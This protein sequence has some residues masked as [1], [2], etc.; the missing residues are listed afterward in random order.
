MKK[1]IIFLVLMVGALI[2]F[3]VIF[4][5]PFI[6]K[7]AE[8]E[9]AL[10]EAL[11][12]VKR[13]YSSPEGPPSTALIKAMEAGDKILEEEYARMRK[14]L[15]R[16][17]NFEVPEGQNPVLYFMET[18]YQKKKE[19]NEYAELKGAKLPSTI[20]GL[21]EKLPS[22]EEVPEL[23]KNL[24]MVDWLIKTFLDNQVKDISS[25]SVYKS[26]DGDIYQKL[27]LTIS[28]SC[29][30]LSFTKLLYFLENNEEKFVLI[31]DLVIASK[32]ISRE[33][34]VEKP[35]SDRIQ[36]SNYR[37]GRKGALSDIMGVEEVKKKTVVKKVLNVTMSISIL[38]WSKM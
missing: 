19:W 25:I 7:K 16:S 1:L 35:E 38:E 31:D 13:F 33:V 28:F 4:A 14:V 6:A 23:L 34:S 21:P 30:L 29:D 9:S 27:P 22:P 18:Y 32:E 5:R 36:P 24:A 11:D 12:K 17:S 8:V 26:E 2:A 10:Q 15:Y 37:R 3:Y 20:S